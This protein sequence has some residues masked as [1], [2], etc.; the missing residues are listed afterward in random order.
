MHQI[1]LQ[2]HTPPDRTHSM[3]RYHYWQV[4]LPQAWLYF[5]S[6]RQMMAWF[7]ELNRHLNGMAQELNWLLADLLQEHRYYIFHMDK[8]ERNAMRDEFRTIDGQ[9]DQLLNPYDHIGGNYVVYMRFNNI[10]KSA[11]RI[12]LLLEANDMNKIATMQRHRLERLRHRADYIANRLLY[13]PTDGALIIEPR[14]T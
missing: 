11:Q 9:F 2:N 14:E 4:L 13:Y 1:K 7:A 6:R 12:I 5:S 8:K 3:T 10:L